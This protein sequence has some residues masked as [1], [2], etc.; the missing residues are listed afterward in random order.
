MEGEYRTLHA[1]KVIIAISPT[2]G[3]LHFLSL[4]AA[5]T[6][7]FTPVQVHPGFYSVELQSN[8]TEFFGASMQNFNNTANF[9][10]PNY[11]TLTLIYPAAHPGSF[12]GHARANSS[13][14]TIETIVATI[15][16]NLEQLREAPNPVDVALVRVSPHTGYFPHFPVD[17]LAYSPYR[18]IYDLQGLRNTFYVGALFPYPD[19]TLI[20]DH[21]KRLVDEH[22]PPK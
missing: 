14:D 9:D 22:F 21:G 6:A 19:T 5:E 15:Q 11:P 18:P 8:N 12:V 7:A 2:I 1:D 16:T 20:T 3:N 10:A 17:E 13:L 4:N